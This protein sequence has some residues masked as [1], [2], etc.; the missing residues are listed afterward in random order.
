MNYQILDDRSVLEIQGTDNIK[1][2]QSLTTNDIS[3]KDQLIYSY[4]LSPQ[5]RFLFDFFSYYNGKTILLDVADNSAELLLKRL[6]L[7]KMRSQIEITT[8]NDLRI[9]YS[10]TQHHDTISQRDPRYHRLGYRSF[11]T[12]N[13]ELQGTAISNLYLNDK[14]SH[15]I[16]DGTYDLEYDKSFPQEFGAEELNAISFDKGCYVGQEVISRTKYQGVIRKK[17]F[18]LNLTQSN[19]NWGETLADDLSIYQAEQKIGKICS[20]H[21]DIA[22]AQIRINLYDGADPSVQFA[23]GT[24]ATISLANWYK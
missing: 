13:A 4:L 23:N 6:N 12:N 17:L 22:I 8:C 24:C 15:A 11:V 18:K 3:K 20:L 9:L 7:Y 1:F 2:L 19:I 16:P 5:G 10:D 21:Q 14:Y